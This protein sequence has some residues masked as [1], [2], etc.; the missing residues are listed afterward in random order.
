MCHVKSAQFMPMLCPQSEG[1]FHKQALLNYGQRASDPACMYVRGMQ[2]K[3]EGVP[4]IVRSLATSDNRHRD[5]IYMWCF[6]EIHKLPRNKGHNGPGA[7][8]EEAL[9]Q[10]LF[11]EGSISSPP[12]THAG[13]TWGIAP[14]RSSDTCLIGQAMPG[15]RCKGTRI[16]AI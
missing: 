7:Y 3:M 14:C 1:P 5:P 13:Q 12:P 8:E 11:I 6:Q 2:Q 16:M 9:G 15:Y 10:G 4:G